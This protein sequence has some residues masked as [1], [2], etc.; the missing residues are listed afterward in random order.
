MN[1]QVISKSA[2]FSHTAVIKSIVKNKRV[3]MNSI[4]IRYHIRIPYKSCTPTV[5]KYCKVLF[6]SALLLRR[7]NRSKQP[8]ASRLVQSPDI[9]CL[10]HHAELQHRSKM[11]PCRPFPPRGNITCHSVFVPVPTLPDDILLSFNL[12]SANVC[13]CYET[14]K[15][16]TDLFSSRRI[17]IMKQ[18]TRN[19]YNHV[20]VMDHWAKPRWAGNPVCWGA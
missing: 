10:H 9:P 8:E 18:C 3:L 1:K 11:F 2:V 15:C 7:R 17:L 20:G 5:S 14:N 19:K 4:Y 12:C 6:P 13:T 16:N